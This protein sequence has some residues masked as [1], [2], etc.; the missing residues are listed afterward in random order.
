MWN[1]FKVFISFVTILLLLYVL[2]TWPQGMR[3][4]RSLNMD[5][6]AASS[7]EGKVLCSGPPGKLLIRCILIIKFI[8]EEMYNICVFYGFIRYALH[9][10]HECLVM[11]NSAP[12]WTVAHQAPPSMGFSRQAYWSGLPFPPPGDLPNIRLPLSPN[13]RTEPEQ[14]FTSP[15][16]A[17]EM[18]TCHRDVY[19]LPNSNFLPLRFN[20]K[21]MILQVRFN[22]R[23]LGSS[24]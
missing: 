4:L 19:S 7:L 15:P 8:C 5:Q 18:C 1:I 9:S 16:L 22:C 10:L 2:V 24:L 21:E 14:D 12:A 3:D 13:Q 11:S 23:C 20:T 17:K 6:I